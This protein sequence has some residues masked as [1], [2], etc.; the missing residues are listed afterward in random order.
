MRDSNVQVWIAAGDAGGRRV[1]QRGRAPRGDEA[2]F[3]SGDR[4]QTG[5]N[6]VCQ[7]VEMHVLSCGSVDGGAHVGQH[8]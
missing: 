8:Q 7:L 3:G 2:P 1:R 5:P 4:S 6:G